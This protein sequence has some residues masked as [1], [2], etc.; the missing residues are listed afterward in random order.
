MTF[1]IE[2]L[3]EIDRIIGQW[4]VLKVPP[5]IKNQIDH[6]YEVDGQAVTLLEVR[7]IFFNLENLLATTNR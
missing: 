2:Q 1:S 4:C 3:G 7:Q 5:E 6:D